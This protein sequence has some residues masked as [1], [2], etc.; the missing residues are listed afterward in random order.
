MKLPA[1]YADRSTHLADLESLEDHWHKESFDAKIGKM[2][3]IA[4]FISFVLAFSFIYSEN[5]P[6]A[7]NTVSTL[8]CLTLVDQAGEE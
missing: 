4:I 8:S 1:D 3:A 5:S 6:A 7:V 2:A